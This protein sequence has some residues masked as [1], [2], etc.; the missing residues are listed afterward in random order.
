[1]TDSTP[2]TLKSI[3][4]IVGCSDSTVSRVLSGKSKQ[5]RISPKT[6]QKI[7]QLARE[8][9][10]APNPLAASLRTRRTLTIGLVIPDISNPFFAGIAPFV[11]RECRKLGYSVLLASTEE[12]AELEIESV[13]IL[14]KRS[15]DGLIIA[16]VGQSFD[17]LKQLYQDGLPMVLIDRYFPESNIPYVTSDNYQG[18]RDAAE[19]MIENG[20]KLIAC[21][22]GSP[23]TLP[24]NERV[25][26]YREALTD[27]GIEVNEEWIVGDSYGEENGYFETRLLLKESKRPTALFALSNLISLGAL[28]AI[29]EEHLRVPEDISII[30]FDEQPYSNLLATP[31]TT[32]SQQ[33]HEMGKIAMQM[34]Y[35]QIRAGKGSA[36]E[37][38]KL[39]TT[40]IRRNSVRAIHT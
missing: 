3:A 27:A 28:R 22:Q 13:S 34:L 29:C 17:H 1:M 7:L 36:E 16:P 30:S 25:R 24:N 26:G 12:N 10:F 33:I 20:H 9:H 37:S 11:Q 32:V 38:V 18:G 39:A 2:I 19:F 15:I 23:F 4:K 35:R 21:I 6:E 8:L 40:L 14:S 31:M 5:Y